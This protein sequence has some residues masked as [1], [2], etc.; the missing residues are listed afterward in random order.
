L[1][2]VQHVP[3]LFAALKPVVDANRS[4]FHSYRLLER[5]AHSPS[6]GLTSRP[7]GDTASLS[8]LAG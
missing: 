1:D 3:E 4:A 5:S 8:T 6:I 7:H 2:E